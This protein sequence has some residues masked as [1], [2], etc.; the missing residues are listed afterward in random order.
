MF[1]LLV[2]NPQEKQEIITVFEGGGYFDQSRVLWDER[3]DGPFPENLRDKVG[4][5]V[6]SGKDLVVDQ[7]KLDAA[8]A[9]KA[10]NDS[11]ESARAS[12]VALAKELL[13]QADL[14][15][16]FTAAEIQAL[17]KSIVIVLRNS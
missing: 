7:A 2:N 17:V 13:R 16:T 15:K 5:L 6:R 10:D 11:R 4:G 12:R 8:A 9:L 14:T 3:K 1:K